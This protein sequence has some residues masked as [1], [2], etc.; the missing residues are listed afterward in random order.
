MPRFTTRVEIHGAQNGDY[1]K[2]HESMEAA[3]FTRTITVK[4][5]RYDPDLEIEIE[6][7]VTYALPTAEY[8]YVTNNK[9]TTQQN[10]LEKARNATSPLK[11]KFSILVTKSD[12]RSFSG[13]EEPR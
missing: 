8:N 12:G 3:G 10:V 5:N 13:L 2:L 7:D 1:E 9:K 11:K 4:E 6:V